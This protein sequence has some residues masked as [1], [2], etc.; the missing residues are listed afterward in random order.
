MLTNEDV[1]R[2][3]A[4]VREELAA[5]ALRGEG[6]RRGGK[7]AEP[8]L[9]LPEDTRVRPAAIVLGL[10]S[11]ARVDQA[12]GGVALRRDGAGFGYVTIG[13]V[14][15]A[16]GVAEERWPTFYPL[17]GRVL[18]GLGW[19]RGE[20]VREKGSRVRVTPF[21]REGEKAEGAAEGGGA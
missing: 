3:R 15:A 9:E 21:Y 14:L 17:A 4:V 1:D 13:D 12:L 6:W 5:A 8:R 7:G 10:F 16:L 19:K 20:R 11:P 2:V 18:E